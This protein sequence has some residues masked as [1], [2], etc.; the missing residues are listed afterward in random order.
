MLRQADRG[1]I[2]RSS[3]VALAS[4]AIGATIV[5]VAVDPAG[6]VPK[7]VTDG[8]VQQAANA[9]AAVAQLVGQ[10]SAQIAQSQAR[11]RS[12]QAQAELAEQKYAYAMQL[13]QEAT[14]AAVKAQADVAAGQKAQQTARTQVTQ[15]ARN[16]YISPQLGSNAVNLLTAPD[17]SAFLQGADYQTF[18]NRAMV[19]QLNAVDRATVALSNLNAKAAQAKQL[20]AKRTKDADSARQQAEQA[21]SAQQAE[22]AQL[23]ATEADAQ[24]RLDAAQLQLATLNNQRN[25]YVA[26]VQK[27][28]AQKAAKAEAERLARIK[29]A[30]EQQ[31]LQNQNNGGSI[32]GGGGGGPAPAGPSGGSWTLAK[33]Q[34]AAAKAVSQLGV[35]YA[36]AG[37]NYYGPTYGVNSPGTDGWNDSQVY[38]FDCSGLVLFAWYPALQLPHYAA[39][40]YLVAGSYHPSPGDFQ[41]GDLL[42]WSDGGVDGIHHVAMYIGNGNVVQAPNSGDVVRITPWQQVA[43]GYYGAT[44]PLT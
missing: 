36:W 2:R 14:A 6:A 8:Q 41:P 5:C 9:K 15:A 16:S 31:R 11:E 43:Y 27:L 37:G 7:R 22:S 33:G 35:R 12:L 21:Y 19:N 40:Q 25:Q 29:A 32:G 38:G 23:Q 1:T 4:L 13:L 3:R 42:F 28:Q 26:Y 44:R 39:S 24:K 34:A 20:Q 30:E 10:L 17:A 18:I